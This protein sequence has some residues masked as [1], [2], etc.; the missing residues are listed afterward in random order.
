[1]IWEYD[2]VRDFRT[3][4]GGMGRGGAITSGL[5]PLAY[6]GALF[7]SSGSDYLNKMPGDVLLAFGAD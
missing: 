1:M 2:T 4:D 6:H 7:V 5:G 3:V